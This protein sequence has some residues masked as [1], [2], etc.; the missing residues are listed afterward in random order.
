MPAALRALA[1]AYRFQRMS[2]GW[3][4]V[5]FGRAAQFFWLDATPLAASG[6]RAAEQPLLRGLAVGH[7]NHQ[8]LAR[9]PHLNTDGSVALQALPRRR[10]DRDGDEVDRV[11]Y[12]LFLW[13]YASSV[14]ANAV[15]FGRPGVALVGGVVMGVVALPFVRALRV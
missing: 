15:F 5:S 10:F 4:A 3:R 7:L 6:T 8:S 14:L 2:V 12:A 11:P 13:T 1:F 9:R